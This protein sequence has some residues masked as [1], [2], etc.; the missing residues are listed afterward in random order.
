MSVS[1]GRPTEAWRAPPSSA[2]PTWRAPSGSGILG[3]S[4][5]APT[6]AK[7]VGPD[8]AQWFVPGPVRSFDRA[9]ALEDSWAAA[10]REATGRDTLAEPFLDAWPGPSS[11]VPALLLN[12]TH[13]QTGRRLVASP[14]TWTSNDLPDTD[15]LLTVLGADIP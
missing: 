7:L 8:F 14:F 12:G 5:L 9:W 4:F 13:V 2:A 3:G 11:G 1:R 10:Y 6:L 15:D